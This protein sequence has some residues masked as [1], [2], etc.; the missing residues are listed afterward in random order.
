MGR[1]QHTAGPIHL[2][3]AE[4]ISGRVPVGLFSQEARFEETGKVQYLFLQRLGQSAAVFGNIF[5]MF[6]DE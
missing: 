3:V 5:E 6:H 2:V 4:R 1:F